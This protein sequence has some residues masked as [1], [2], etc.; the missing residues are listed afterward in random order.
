MSYYLRAE[1]V[2]LGHFV[3]DTND[4][5]TT[6]GGGLL[7]LEAMENVETIINNSS[8][9]TNPV[10][11][12]INALQDKI[13]TINNEI[14]EKSAPSEATRRK[15][16]RDKRKKLEK[17]KKK[18]LANNESNT[19]TITKGASWGLFNVQV[20]T[21]EKAR[22]IYAKVIESLT[23]DPR[24]KHATF[25]VDLHTNT[26]EENYQIDRDRLQTLN[27]WQ[28]MQAPSLAICHSGTTS[29]AVDKTRPASEPKRYLKDNKK[30]YV[31]ESVFQ[32]R[33]YGRDQKQQFYKKITDIEARYTQDLI[34]L[35]QSDKQNI[36]GGKIAFIYIDGNDFGSMQ[37]SSTNP[38]EQKNFDKSTREGRKQVLKNILQKIHNDADWLTKESTIR[39]ET[40]LW[41]GDEIIWVVPAWKGWR[42]IGE[43]Y[44]EAKRHIKLQNEQ[45]EKELFHATGIVFCHHNA[46]IHRIDALARQ[47]AEFSKSDRKKNLIAYQILE[48]FDHAG[49][50]ISD[51]RQSR[52]CNLGKSDH[53]LIKE[54]EIGAIQNCIT[55]L[56]DNDFPRRKIYQIVQ[57]YKNEETRKAEQYIAKLPEKSIKPLAELKRIFGDNNAHW[58]HLMDLW[59][60]MERTAPPCKK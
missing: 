49:T 33:E 28:Q 53:L 21:E 34:T 35:S 1:G 5:S 22:A 24:Y 60:Y 19:Q 3:N 36:L 55:E 10:Q 46:P 18:L 32:R 20:S 4:L 16:L 27:R 12:E 43:F 47:L 2:N 57:A 51:F 50:D 7:L 48:S 41:G 44:K 45:E 30:E 6:R 25:V 39:L 52:I 54:E 56:K 29:C 11:N 40:L 13:D 26:G 14:K 15:N 42:M 38:I 59:D 8:E 37:K 17:E 58:L 23:T 31:S 9:N